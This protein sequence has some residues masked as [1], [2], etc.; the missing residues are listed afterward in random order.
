MGLNFSFKKVANYEEVTTDPADE[1][2][3]HPVAD[4]LV[5]LSM[6]CGYREINAKNVD[7]VITRI[8]TYQAVAGAYLSANAGAI[9]VYITPEDVRRFIGLAT[10]ASTMTDA[11]W[12]KHIARIATDQGGYLK[13]R[14]ADKQ[15]PTAMSEVH[16]IWTEAQHKQP[17]PV[18]E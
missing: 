14:L 8:M 2:R 17:V 1:T 11:Q 12:A 7:K 15:T 5:W 6:I 18:T 13:H 4:A 10:N 9:K 16:R 3:W